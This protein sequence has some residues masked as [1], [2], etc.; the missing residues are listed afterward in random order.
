MKILAFGTSN[1]RESINRSLASYAAGLVASAEVEIL[2]I[3]DYEMPLFSDEREHALGQPPQARAFLQK[4]AEADALV[5]S[6]V[7]H[8]G[9]R[10]CLC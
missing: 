1:N 7:E 5:V 2:N 4:I 8:N 3:N 9:S 10:Q 6:F